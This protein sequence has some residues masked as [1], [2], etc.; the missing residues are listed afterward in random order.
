HDE[1]DA[2]PERR[3]GEAEYTHYRQC[4]VRRASLVDCGNDPGSYPDDDGE[5]E[6]HRG[7]LER[8]RQLGRNQARDR[9]AEAH[10]WAEGP[11]DCLGQ[12]ADILDRYRL[13]QPE[14]LS[15]RCDGLR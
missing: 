1:E 7:E 14:T 12:P 10:R 4:M 15:D 5:E 8:D 3:D 9:L 6:R 2:Q 13:I 11:L